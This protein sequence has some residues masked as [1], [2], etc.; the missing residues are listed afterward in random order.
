MKI[1]YLLILFIPC[2]LVAGCSSAPTTVEYYRLAAPTSKAITNTDGKK[3]V[4]EAISLPTFLTQAGLVMTTDDNQIRISRLNRRRKRRICPIGSV[5][6]RGSKERRGAEL[7]DPDLHI[8]MPLFGLADVG[9]MQPVPSRK[10]WLM[11]L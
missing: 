3:L 1:N 6:D 10:S 11:C 8:S 4:I 7:F 2:L 5:V 9:A